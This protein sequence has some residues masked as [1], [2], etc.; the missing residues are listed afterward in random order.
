MAEPRF[1]QTRH[2]LLSLALSPLSLL[3]GGLARD[4]RG[5]I[6][7]AVVDPQ[8]GARLYDDAVTLGGEKIAEQN[9]FKLGREALKPQTEI[10]DV[11]EELGPEP[12][13][14]QIEAAK[15]GMRQHIRTVLENVKGVPSDQ[16]LAARQ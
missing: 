3:Y 13:Q 10:G 1:W 7:Q 11:L 14:A 15:L 16:E 4:L 5:A 8:T 9:A 2:H 6:G 12:S